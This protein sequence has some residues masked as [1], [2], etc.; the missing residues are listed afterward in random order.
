MATPAA[1]VPLALWLGLGVEAPRVDPLVG[2]LYAGT[3]GLGVDVGPVM[4]VEVRG[5]AAW[6]PEP[7]PTVTDLSMIGRWGNGTVTHQDRAGWGEARVGFAPLMG[8]V[9]TG[10]SGAQLAVGAFVGGGAISIIEWTTWDLE[11]GDAGLVPSTV[12]GLSA[13]VRFGSRRLAAEVYAEGFERSWISVERVATFELQH[14][15]AFGVG[16]RVVGR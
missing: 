14:D 5:G 15:V 9:G 13:R 1:A 7:E 2:G 16:V 8:T 11:L 6:I 12:V 10:G 3:V 4:W